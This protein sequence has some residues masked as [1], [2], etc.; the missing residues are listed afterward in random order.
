[1]VILAPYVQNPDCL[2]E[3]LLFSLKCIHVIFFLIWISLKS[4]L[5]IT[6]FIICLYSKY[7]N[8]L[9]WGLCVT[10]MRKYWN[11]VEIP[12]H[13]YLYPARKT[14]TNLG[15]VLWKKE[16]APAELRKKMGVLF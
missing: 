11:N 14:E 10:Y 16:T 4:F 5:F 7:V 12:S 3:L 1:M 15:K 6:D 13:M 2:K 8:T 9:S